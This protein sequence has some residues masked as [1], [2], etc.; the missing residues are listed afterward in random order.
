MQDNGHSG[1]NAVSTTIS[2][3]VT[4]IWPWREPLRCESPERA[5]RMKA[6]I[7]ALVLA[8][9]GMLLVFRLHHV[10]AGL[11]V[12]TI[13]MCLYVV[14]V[15]APRAFAPVDRLAVRAGTV[16]AAGLTWLLLV[17]FFYVV[18]GTGR[19]ILLVTGKD[20]LHGRKLPGERSYWTPHR[21]RP[22][23]KQYENQF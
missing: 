16:A 10:T 23:A 14:G 12:S 4:A 19:L 2:P 15:G 17:P 9:I 3:V 6:M 18:F 5:L 13:A 11:V 7:Q 20:P 8:A 1:L 21:G 22:D